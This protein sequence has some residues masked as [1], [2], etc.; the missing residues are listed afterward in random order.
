[1]RYSIWRRCSSA[2][3]E[4][5]PA[6]RC[7]CSPRGGRSSWRISNHCCGP[8]TCARAGRRRVVPE[9]PLPGCT[10]EPLMCY[11]TALGVFRLVAEQAD[12]AATLCWK[13]G[14]AHL[15]SRRDRDGLIA[16]FLDEYKPTPILAPWNGGSGFFDE[17]DTDS[18]LGLLRHSGN[19]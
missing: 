2:G 4:V 18:A 14:V 10:P 11:L 16:F 7:G 5:G 12:P 13:G 6:A 15:V 8:P 9:L 3:K 17:E 1:K 19:P